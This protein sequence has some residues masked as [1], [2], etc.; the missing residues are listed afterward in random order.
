MRNWKTLLGRLTLVGL[1]ILLQI[2]FVLILLVKLD[3]Y[4]KVVQT[5]MTIL[6]FVVLIN[7]VNRDMTTEAKIPWIILVLSLPLTGTVLYILFSGNRLSK[8]QKKRYRRILAKSRAYFHQDILEEDVFREQLGEYAGQCM[9]IHH[10]TGQVAYG[11]TDVTYYPLGED[12][13][14]DLLWELEKAQ[15]YIF[16]EY[17]IVH[18]G[19]MWNSI[20]AILERKVQEGVEV[21]FMYDDLGS[22]ATLPAD[23]DRFLCAKG[24]RCIKVN[25]FTPIVSEVHNNRDHRKI[26]VIDGQVGFIG[27][28]NLAD[29]YINVAHPYGH[30]KDTSLKLKGKG[31]KGLTLLFLQSFNSQSRG[32][33]DDFS[34]Y[35][36]EKELEYSAQ[37]LVL[38][39]GDGPRPAYPDYIAENVY[40]NMIAQAQ[41]YLWITTPYL[42]LDNR[43]RNALCIAAQRGVD[44]RIVTPHIPDKKFVFQITRSNYKKLQSAGVKI[45]EYLPGFI[46]AKQF[47]CDDQVGIVGTINLDYRSLVHHFEC[48]VWMYRTDCLKDMKADF[49]QLFQISQNMEGY[50]QARLM[51]I[52]CRIT[53]VFVP[54]L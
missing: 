3:A 6:S 17:F 32:E 21:R 35:I 7:I 9:Y 22:V 30:W 4:Y 46:H 10:A 41:R 5:T 42:I 19:V 51:V 29:E 18:P 27:G 53:H 12:F 48:G 38:P 15:K 23:Y 52:L 49:E 39:Y 36:P 31:V 24:I 25:P 43:L 54:L 16:M 1:A 34:S 37:G 13:F 50:Q 11:N 33:M 8:E 20:L 40:L 14:Q 26:T 28:A 45:Y 47:L 2:G 44:V